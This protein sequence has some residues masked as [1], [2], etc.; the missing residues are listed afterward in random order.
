[1]AQHG[2]QWKHVPKAVAVVHPTEHNTCNG[3]VTFTKTDAGVEVV[4][5][6]Q[7]LNPSQKHAIHVHE[8]G[9]CTKPDGT[10][11]GSHYN[12]EGHPHALPAQDGRHAGDLGNL[13]ADAAGKARYQVTVSNL[14]I[15]GLK[16][17]V[18]GRAVIV[19]AKPDDGGQPTGNAGPR[20]GCGVIGIA[21]P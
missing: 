2:A 14:S 8:Y 13:T 10:S 11:A 21:K 16:N 17:P 3:V 9:D 4:A 7:G 20:I 1:M 18:I 19:H 6:I 5:V 15:A 12:P